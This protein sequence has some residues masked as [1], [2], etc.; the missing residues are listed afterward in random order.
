MLSPTFNRE[1]YSAAPE[2]QLMGMRSSATNML[3]LQGHFKVLH[4]EFVE[5]IL[6]GCVVLA[7]DL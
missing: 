7:E 2:T 4:Y 5:H 6:S 1:N 3:K